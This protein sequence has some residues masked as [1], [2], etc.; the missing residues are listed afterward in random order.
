[1]MGRAYSKDRFQRAGFR[2]DEDGGVNL[3]PM[4]DL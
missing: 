4:Y 1:M 3:A 2:F